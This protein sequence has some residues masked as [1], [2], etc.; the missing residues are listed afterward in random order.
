MQFKVPQDVQRADTIVGPLTW[1]QLIILAAGGA[2][3]YAIYV[4][5]AKTYYM[6][7]WLPPIVLIGGLTVAMAFLKIHGLDFERFLVCFI[8]YNF[9]PKKRR[10]QKG[11]AEDFVIYLQRKAEEKKTPIP[12]KN[13]EENGNKKSIKELS[14]ILDSYGNVKEEPNAELNEAIAEKQEK[15]TILNKIINHQA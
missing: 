12:Q 15:K 2:I 7:V 13:I 5:L 9:L 10:W 11:E 6:E 8:E 3:C 4:S 1:K 14:E